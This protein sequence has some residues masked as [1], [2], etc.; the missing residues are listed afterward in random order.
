M[1]RRTIADSS[2]TAKTLISVP[3]RNA[4]A[5]PM[6]SRSAAN[7]SPKMRSDAAWPEI[8]YTV[9]QRNFLLVG[10]SSSD[11]IKKALCAL[12]LLLETG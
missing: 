8:G 5:S 11:T 1:K 9:V 7:T 2:S 4:L 12:L 6:S 10:Q 3:R